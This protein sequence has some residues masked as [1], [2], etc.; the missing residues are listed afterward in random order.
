MIAYGIKTW[1]SI[2]MPAVL[3]LGLSVFLF[4]QAVK[5]NL[6]IRDEVE[7]YGQIT[8]Y[9]NETA[10]ERLLEQKISEVFP[11]GKGSFVYEIPVI[12]QCNSI[13]KEI[14]VTGIE[15][16]MIP[17][18]LISGRYYEDNVST[19][20]IV[21]NM[22]AFSDLLR[23]DTELMG[24]NAADFR[25][26]ASSNETEANVQNQRGTD[27]SNI[28]GNDA[29]EKSEADSCIGR[30][31]IIGNCGAKICGMIDDGADTS[32]LYIS[33]AAAEAYLKQQGEI[34]KAVSYCVRIPDLKTLMKTQEKMNEMGISTSVDDSKLSQWKLME[35]RRK[36]LSIMGMIAFA[37]FVSTIA[38]S[39]K[40][41]QQ[42]ETLQSV[43]VCAARV[44]MCLS[45]GS[46]LGVMVYMLASLWYVE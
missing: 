17:G 45:V 7:E 33:V 46:I 26:T 44:G 28:R 21:M 14:N 15:T 20:E 5:M 35:C 4:L 3:F 12:L 41:R 2:A 40:W 36:D 6:T 11:G 29:V 13:S 8:C 19:P 38:L 31:L 1:K 25:G 10:Q 9:I 34:P 24:M 32:S 27:S 39:I 42:L 37:G 23:A 18:T 43:R 16:Q 22:A 30:T